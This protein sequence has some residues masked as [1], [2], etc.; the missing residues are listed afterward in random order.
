[1]FVFHPCFVKGANYLFDVQC[2]V[3]FLQNT[4]NLNHQLGI[5][6]FI[7]T[8]T[9]LGFNM[10]TDCAGVSCGYIGLTV[11][12][13]IKFAVTHDTFH[14][15]SKTFADCQ[16]ASLL[17]HSTEDATILKTAIKFIN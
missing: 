16:L 8:L 15:F 13:V 10:Y 3:P 9:A 12:F 4:S 11:N 6:V 17:I 14:L 2:V 7:L 5:E 1:M